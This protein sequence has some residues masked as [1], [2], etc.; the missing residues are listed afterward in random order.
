[1]PIVRLQPKSVSY[2]MENAKDWLAVNIKDSKKMRIATSINR[3]GK[4][5]FAQMDTVIVSVDM[6]GDIEY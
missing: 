4:E 3:T 1:M 5:N 6:T 2:Q